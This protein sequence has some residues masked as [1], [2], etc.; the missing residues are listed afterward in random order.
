M[1]RWKSERGMSLVEVVVAMAIAGIALMGAMG[2][3]QVSARFAQQGMMKTRALSLAQGRL[4][5]KRSV[6]WDALLQDDLNHDGAVD[7]TMHDDGTGG[8][9]AGNTLEATRVDYT[10]QSEAMFRLPHGSGQ[11]NLQSLLRGLGRVQ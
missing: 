5:A 7:V 4:E 9:A 11:L 10:P 8:D 2:A 1:M 6:R 3:V